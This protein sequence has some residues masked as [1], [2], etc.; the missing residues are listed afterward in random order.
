MSGRLSAYRRAERVGPPAYGRDFRLYFT[1]RAVSVI[2]DRIALIALTFLVI[3]LS[4]SFAPALGIFYLCRLLPTLLGGLLA[5]V[6]VDAMHRKSLMVGCDLGRA[7]LLAV[8]PAV[9][10]LA[11]W[12]L[13]PLVV[14]LYGLTLLFDTAARA[15]LPDVVPE[16]RLM[17][18]NSLLEGIEMMGDVSYVVGGA[19]V[20]VLSLRAPFYID[21]GTFLF[22]AAV[23]SAMELPSVPRAPLVGVRAV[24]D[25]VREG[26]RYLIGHPFLKWSTVALAVAPVAGGAGFV[27]APLYADHVLA[28]GFGVVGPLRSGAFRFG[29]LQAGEGF[30]AVLGSLAAVPLASRRPRGQLFALGITGMGV[31]DGVLALVTNIYIATGALFVS[32][33]FNGLYV[34]SGLTLVQTLASSEVRGRVLTARYTVTNSALALGSVLAGVLLLALSYRSLWLLDGAV[35]VAGSLVVWLHPAARQQ[36]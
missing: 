9:N 13:Y 16:E 18:A 27:L 6:L 26:I 5:G 1:A 7:V 34:V 10:G 23:V 30:G 14:V 28:H 29:V 25:R 11:L 21:A 17:A 24:T 22:S 3:H 12:T 19:L 31:A 15:A 8:V 20:Y 32:G 36:A 35:M 33:V 2:G 4:R